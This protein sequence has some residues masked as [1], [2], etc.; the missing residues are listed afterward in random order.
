MKEFDSREV[1]VLK[2]VV[3]LEVGAVGYPQLVER[4]YTCIGDLTSMYDCLHKMEITDETMSG[5]IWTRN[6]ETIGGSIR[7]RSG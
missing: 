4:V 2:S 7:K 1:R 3:H 5:G 6:R